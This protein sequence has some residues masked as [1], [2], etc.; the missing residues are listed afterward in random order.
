[1]EES[2]FIYDKHFI[3]SHKKE[4]LR[5][6]RQGKLNPEGTDERCIQFAN[7]V[8]IT[9]FTPMFVMGVLYNHTRLRNASNRLAYIYEYGY[10]V[11][12]LFTYF[13]DA[14][15]RDLILIFIDVNTLSIVIP[16]AYNCNVDA[17]LAKEVFESE[18]AYKLYRL[19]QKEGQTI[20][21]KNRDL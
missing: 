13:Q 2:K 11:D 1:M 5:I 3:L 10:L 12:E 4:I 6:I 18:D 21:S 8:T 14:D 17:R 15:L 19:Q 20:I 16:N 7:L 9:A